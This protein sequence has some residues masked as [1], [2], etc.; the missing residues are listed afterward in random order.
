M[1]PWLRVVGP[2]RV[3]RNSGV[4]TPAGPERAEVTIIPKIMLSW[5]GAVLA[6]GACIVALRLT[7]HPVL[8]ASLGGSCVI[9]FGMSDGDM[10][11]PRSLFLGHLI[12]ASVGIAFLRYGVPLGGPRDAWMVAAVATS[13]ATMMATRTIHSPAGA[14]PIVVFMEG[15]GWSFL[16]SPVL[17]GLAIVFGVGL[18]VNN[19]RGGRYPRAW[20]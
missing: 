17:I 4:A 19:F 9:V 11:Q 2:D 10:A 1:R 5:T 15:A 13:L 20:R 8:L 18:L 7:A 16:W 3:G 12:A 14:N 6:L